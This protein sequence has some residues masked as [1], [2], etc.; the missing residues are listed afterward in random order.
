MKALG[1]NV[2]IA[3]Q[4]PLRTRRNKDFTV[5]VESQRPAQTMGGNTLPLRK[6]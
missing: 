2:N 3:G 5:D 1:G 6:W 4:N